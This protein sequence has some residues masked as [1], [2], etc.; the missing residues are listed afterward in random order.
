MTFYKAGEFAKLIGV[1]STTLRNWDRQNLL[2]PHHRTPSGY[3]C[4]SQDQLNEYL[5]LTDK[6]KG[7]DANV[8]SQQI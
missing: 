1:T 6:T 4:Y 7:G 2:K 8:R 3:R 5:G